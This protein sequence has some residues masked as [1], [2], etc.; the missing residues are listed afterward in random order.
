MKT[1]EIAREL[2]MSGRRRKMIKLK[3]IKAFNKLKIKNG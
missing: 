3:K 2:M 1:K